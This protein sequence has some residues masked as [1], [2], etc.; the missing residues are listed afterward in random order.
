MSTKKQW[1]WAIDEDDKAIITIRDMAGR[2]WDLFSV[3]NVHERGK[4]TMLYLLF[5]RYEKESLENKEFS[6]EM[7]KKLL[8]ENAQVS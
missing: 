3:T 6:P 7:T 4:V 8:V 2:G 5:W 1:E